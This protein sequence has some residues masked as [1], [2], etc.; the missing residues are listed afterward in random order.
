MGRK[1]EK[2]KIV[3]LP[4]AHTLKV[5]TLSPL[6]LSLEHDELHCLVA[7]VAAQA[8]TQRATER[9]MT[10][11][12]AILLGVS[13]LNRYPSLPKTR[14]TRYEGVQILASGQVGLS[15]GSST[16]V[17]SLSMGG[18]Q[19]SS[20]N[21][22]ANGGKCCC[23]LRLGEG[24]TRDKAQNNNVVLSEVAPSNLSEKRRQCRFFNEA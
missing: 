6:S 16:V 17:T 18:V 3:W 24:C 9:N 12:V 8:K 13:D 4:G 21:E 20:M 5:R 22:I 2:P 1:R 11:F 7:D 14:T 10:Y 23:F 19:M 15:H